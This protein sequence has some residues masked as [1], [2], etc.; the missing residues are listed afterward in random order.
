MEHEKNT[1]MD[2]LNNLFTLFTEEGKQQN[3]NTQNKMKKNP[4][5]NYFCNEECY[6]KFL[7][8][9]DRLKNNQ[10]DISKINWSQYQNS[11]NLI[12]N[13]VTYYYNLGLSQNQSYEKNK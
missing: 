1:I 12:A 6:K 11:D 9:I 4:L 8:V 7:R 5:K 13:L 10:I 3:D 2:S